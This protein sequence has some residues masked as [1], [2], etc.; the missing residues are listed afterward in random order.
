MLS[1]GRTSSYAVSALSELAKSDGSWVLVTELSSAIGAP[2]PYLA[3]ILHSLSES[4]LVRTKRG[5]KGGYALARPAADISVLEVIEAVEGHDPLSECLLGQEFCTDDRACPTH[6]FWKVE[7]KRIRDLLANL[8][9]DSVADF[10]RRSQAASVAASC[11]GL[12]V[13]VT[14]RKQ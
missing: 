9:L 4:G 2:Q 13:T 8:S 14:G 10:E 11:Q 12:N 5:Y 3:K 6:E 7:R 1:I